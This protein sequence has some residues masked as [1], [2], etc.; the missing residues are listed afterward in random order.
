MHA[1]FAI[2]TSFLNKSNSQKLVIL[3]NQ[4]MSDMR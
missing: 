3:F 2:Y 4:K 1:F